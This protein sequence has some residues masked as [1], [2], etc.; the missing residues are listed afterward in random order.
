VSA[1]SNEPDAHLYATFRPRF[2][3]IA[4]T[5]TA[6]VVVGG[7]VWIAATGTGPRFD[8]PQRVAI[9][10]FGVLCGLLV[11]LLVG[12]SARATPRELRV[13]NIVRARTLEWPEVVAVRFGRNDPW[14][15][16][17]LADGKTIAVM[18]VQRADG[19]RGVRE[20]NR[21]A[22]LVELHGEALEAD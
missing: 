6:V 19:A 10:V 16:L 13:R 14:V 20:A 1:E 8:A 18:A 3:R 12:V 7:C 11:W 17:D 9:I 4:G 15:T 5:I 2:A 22:R 21:L